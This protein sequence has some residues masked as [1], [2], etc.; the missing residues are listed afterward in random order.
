MYL[1]YR[2]SSVHHFANHFQGLLEMGILSQIDI[3]CLHVMAEFIEVAHG[4][5]IEV[6]C[7]FQPNIEWRGKQFQIDYLHLLLYWFG[8]FQ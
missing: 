6:C 1:L 5:T 7:R 8:K 2:T 3:E 4:L